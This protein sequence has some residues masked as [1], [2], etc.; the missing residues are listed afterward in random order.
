MK[1][2]VMI[3]ISELY[4]HPENPRKDLGDLTELTESIRKNGIMQNLTVVK[5]HQMTKAEF[6]AEARAEGADKA[7]AEGM[8][9]PEDAWTDEGYTVVIGNR[10][11]EASKA[12]GLAEVPCVISEMDHREQIST[13]LEENMQRADL[14]V[15]EQAQGFQMMMDLGYSAKE[16]S[17]KTGFSETTV[18][19]RLKMAQLDKKT[20]QAAV[21][22]QITID[23]LDQI[24]KI[25]D[26]GKRNELLKEFGEQNFNWTL[27]RAIKE[28]QADKVRPAAKRMIEAHEPKLKQIPT[29]DR[30]N[31]W[32][33]FEKLHS[34]TLELDEWDGK[35]EFI[36]ES[37][38][39]LY[40]LENGMDIEFYIKEKKQKKEAEKKTPEEIEKERQIDLA[41]KT[42]DRATRT[43]AELRAKFA[44]GLTVKPSNAMQML[45]WAIIAALSDW[46]NH[47]YCWMP[48]KAKFELTG[49]YTW[50]YVDDLE[51]K[52]MEM[53]QKEWPGLI[54]MLFEGLPMNDQIETFASGYRKEWPK[55][56]RNTRLEQCYKWL[57]EFG[58][59]MSDEE[60][61]M[62][63]G[64]HEC[65]GKGAA[66]NGET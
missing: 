40:W 1:E 63:S 33:K 37:K 46:A 5:G 18:G 52:L 6:V 66:K 30:Y 57:T 44:E 61:R 9:N 21:G 23:V 51:R 48:L 35:S 58:Y 10:R 15:Y 27:T 54:L 17:E 45:R 38:E 65:F 31:L 20:F 47:K 14:T 12:A 39:P 4:H 29:T 8:Y 43:A 50:D 22:K 13:M 56:K 59:Q 28:Q 32:G 3:P 34:A 41:W 26:I 19:R 60:I 64:T 49:E 42:A 24:G 7:S 53:P 36:P 11:M 2:I 62:M 16:I 25:E 55:W